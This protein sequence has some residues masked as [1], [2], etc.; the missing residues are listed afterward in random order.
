MK[1]LEIHR[2]VGSDGE[3]IGRDAAGG[4]SPPSKS[5]DHNFRLRLRHDRHLQPPAV[6]EILPAIALSSAAIAFIAFPFSYLL[7]ILENPEPSAANSYSSR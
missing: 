6:A 5:R 7:R 2:A 3:L 4:T 1:G